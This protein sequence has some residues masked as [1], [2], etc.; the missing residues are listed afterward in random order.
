VA[1]AL[2]ATIGSFLN[3]VVARLPRG[4]SLVRPSSRCPACH[5]PIHWFD[6]V[7][8]LSYALLRGRCR[9]CAYRISGRYPFIEAGTAALFALAAW[10]LGGRPEVLGP[11]WVLLAALIAIT[12][13][14]L[15]HQIIP[16]RI[17]VPGIAAGFLAALVDPRLT[18]TESLLGIALGAALIFVV[19]VASRGGMGGGDMKLCAMIGAFLGWKLA[20]LTILLAVVL[21]GLVAVTLLIVGRKRRRDAIPFGPFLAAGAVVSL[22]W[23]EELLAWYWAGFAA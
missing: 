15:E 5:T 14:D 18:W 11:A 2:G 12:A 13:I 20:L 7:P 4:E 3:V 22:L 6:N 16:D 17:T 10:R 8:V 23:G 19:I 1:L 9:H 21:G